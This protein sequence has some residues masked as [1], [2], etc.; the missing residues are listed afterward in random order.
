MMTVSSNLRA[1]WH[2][3]Y[4]VVVRSI[5]VIFCP[6]AEVRIG[7]EETEFTVDEGEV[8]VQVCARILSG[9]LGRDAD[10][11][12]QTVDGSAEGIEHTQLNT[13][14]H[15]FNLTHTSHFFARSPQ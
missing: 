4:F 9:S 2:K 12:F 14:L 3:S 1:I 5:H 10:V 11:T 8:I 15:N 13:T 6:C 7:L